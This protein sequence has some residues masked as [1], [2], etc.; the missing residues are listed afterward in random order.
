M[1]RTQGEGRENAA[2]PLGTFAA[3]QKEQNSP[4]MDSLKH[5]EAMR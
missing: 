4:R 3:C 5:R 2:L 1:C